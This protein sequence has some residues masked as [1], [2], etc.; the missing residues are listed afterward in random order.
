MKFIEVHRDAAS[1]RLG[2]R[3]RENG[4]I[5]RDE[6]SSHTDIR[7]LPSSGRACSR[8]RC[9]SSATRSMPNTNAFRQSQAHNRIEMRA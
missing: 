6:L 5:V 8:K 4:K 2:F 9:T 1:G 3:V 7:K